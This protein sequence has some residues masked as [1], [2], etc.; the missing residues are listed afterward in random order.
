MNELMWASLGII[1][2]FVFAILVFLYFDTFSRVK[3]L[4]AV[5]KRNY[6]IVFLVGRGKQI[7]TLVKNLDEDTIWIDNNVWIIDSNKIYRKD[8]KTNINAIESKHINTISGIPIL[9]LSLESM[10]PLDFYSDENTV[11]PEE[12]GATLRAWLYN[13]YAKMLFF[14][15]TIEIAAIVIIV[16]LL[17]I[18]FFSYVSYNNSQEIVK[19]S[20][21]TLEIVK[22][23][24]ITK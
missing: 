21:E 19:I 7:T 22:N 9:F 5:T 17:A 24:T 15:K 3:I 11:K 16:L 12:I 4:R 14:K 23:I 10:K 8:N 13:Q 20:K 6:G 18:T 2:G 1:A